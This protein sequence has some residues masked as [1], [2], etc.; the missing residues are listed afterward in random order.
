MIKIKM[1][2]GLFLVFGCGG[3]VWSG[4]KLVCRFIFLEK[5]NEKWKMKLNKKYWLF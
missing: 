3:F 5:I 2:N 1:F 4:N